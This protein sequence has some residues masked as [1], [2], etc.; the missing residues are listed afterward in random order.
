MVITTCSGHGLFVFFK[1]C[2]EEEK[3]AWP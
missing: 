1:K 2:Y 3:L